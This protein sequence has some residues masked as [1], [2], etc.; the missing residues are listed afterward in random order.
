[1]RRH[2]ALAA[3][4][5]RDGLR[6]CAVL[7][8]AL[9]SA[10]GPAWGQPATSTPAAAVATLPSVIPIF[11]LPEVVLFP[12]A[13]RPL[14]I[15]EPRYRDMV[16]E[17]LKGDRII[18]MVLLRRGY[19]GDYEGRP[20]IH[21]IGCAGEI[22]HFERLP[23]GRYTIVLRGFVKFRV[24]SEDHRRTYRLARVEAVPERVAAGDLGAL[25]AVREQLSA[26]LLASLP[27]G[28]GLPEPALADIDFINLVAQNLHMD[29]T[30]RQELLERSTPLSRAQ[31]LV[32]I[33]EA[34]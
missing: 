2:E 26:L 24:I 21:A 33:L 34:Q 8:G 4:I 12:G 20:P 30:D 6:T 1:M 27:L 19:E 17:A 14:L 15:F 11:P 7:L 5:T 13:S 18:G 22:V 10:S 3:A 23:D 16:A 32:D 28:S 31:A 9:L 25:S 29:E